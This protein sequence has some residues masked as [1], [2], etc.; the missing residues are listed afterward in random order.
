M[1]KYSTW[2]RPMAPISET[3]RAVAWHFWKVELPDDIPS[4]VGLLVGEQPGKGHNAALPLWPYP[5]QSAGARLAR[6]SEIPL[7]D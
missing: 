7:A 6:M 4:P 2:E 5:P 1:T 3:V